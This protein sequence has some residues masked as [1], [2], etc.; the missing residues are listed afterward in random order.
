MDRILPSDV[1]PG[2]IACDAPAYAALAMR[3]KRPMRDQWDVAIIGSGAG[4]APL[5]MRLSQA[6]FSVL[7][8]EKGPRYQR[9]EYRHD[10]ALFLANAAG[11]VPSPAD[12]PHVLL[13]RDAN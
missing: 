9:H 1:G 3:Q 11:F 6:G 13:F 5:A 12:D 8:L 2:A 4:G 10:E 7:V